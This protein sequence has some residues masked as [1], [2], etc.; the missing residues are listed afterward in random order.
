MLRV[1]LLYL[2]FTKTTARAIRHVTA[3]SRRTLCRDCAAPCEEPSAEIARVE[4]FSLWRR[5]NLQPRRQTLCGDCAC[6]IALAVAPGE[7]ATSPTNPLRRLCVSNRSRSGAV[8]TVDFAE[9][10]SGRSCTLARRHSKTPK[11]IQ[12]PEDFAPRSYISI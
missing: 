11:N 7:F 12:R 2:S 3:I 4:L 5:A 6:R 10:P 1:L 9:E 8:R